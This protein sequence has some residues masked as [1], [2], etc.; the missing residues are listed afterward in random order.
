MVNK[1]I[2]YKGHLTSLQRLEI[3]EYLVKVGNNYLFLIGAAYGLYSY[4][5]DLNTDLSGSNGL[6]EQIL[7]M[8]CQLW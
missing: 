2:W 1:I 6:T 3:V 5:P 4:A 7:R 8:K